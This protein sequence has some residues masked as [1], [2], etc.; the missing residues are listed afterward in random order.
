MKL[1]F[2]CIIYSILLF[3]F[4]SDALLSTD[5]PSEGL[6]GT[7]FDFC[8]T[9]QISRSTL[10]LSNRLINEGNAALSVRGGI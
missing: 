1:Q 5:L 6:T 8:E 9:P 10:E 4:G 2:L 7:C 3:G